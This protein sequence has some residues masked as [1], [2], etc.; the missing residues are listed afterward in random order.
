MRLLLLNVY[1]RVFNLNPFILT[2]LYLFPASTHE[3]VPATVPII[4]DCEHT[5]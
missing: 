1:Y 2:K 5:A 3:I 4:K